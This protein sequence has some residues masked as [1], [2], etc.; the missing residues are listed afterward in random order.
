MVKGIL[1][2]KQYKNKTHSNCGGGAK[3]K[4]DEKRNRRGKG[5]G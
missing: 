2:S 5:K 1:T 3:K 4:S